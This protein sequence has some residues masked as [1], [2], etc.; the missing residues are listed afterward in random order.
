MHNIDK[1]SSHRGRG[2]TSWGSLWS[3]RRLQSQAKYAA[4]PHGFPWHTILSSFSSISSPLGSSWLFCSGLER[5]LEDFFVLCHTLEQTRHLIVNPYA[6]LELATANDLAPFHL[7]LF[8]NS[9]H[10]G[11]SHH[12]TS[13][14]P[15]VIPNFPFLRGW[16]TC[17]YVNNYISRTSSNVTSG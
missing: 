3:A 17:I 10:G 12:G 6:S 14:Q 1:K 2:Q 7:H 4:L 5:S 15:L 9:L 11:C 8:D 16:T 13:G